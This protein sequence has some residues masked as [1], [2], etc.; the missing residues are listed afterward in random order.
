MAARWG[1]SS[2]TAWNAVLLSLALAGP[3]LAQSNPGPVKTVPES[4]VARYL[5]GRIA[6]NAGAWDVATAN[7]GAALRQDP[8]N[9]ALMRRTFLLSLGE[10]RQEEALTLARRMTQSEQGGSFV[11]HALLVADALRA[12]RLAEATERVGKLPADGM[13]PYIGPLLQ[14]W[15]A[16]AQGDSDKAVKALDP[17]SAHDGFQAIRTQQL[18]MIEDLRGNRDAAFRHFAEAAN[19]G[20]PLRL[21]LLIGNF[22]ERAGAKD[23]ARKLYTSFLSANPGNMPVEEALA[24]LDRPGP[25][26][27]LVDN[28]A[29][30]LAE[31]LFSLASALHHEGALEMALLYGRVSL[32]L[33][34][35]QPLARILVGDI[36]SARDR[37]ETALTEYRTIG[38]TASPAMQWMARLRQVEVLRE[39]KHGEEATALLEKMAAERPERTDALLRLGDMHRIA[40]HNDAA[41]AAYDKAL[42]RVK[43]PGPGDWALHY[44][45]AM[46][47]DAKGD[48]PGAEA[49][50]KQALALQPDQPSVLNY[51]GYSYIDRGIRMEEG[52]ALIEKALAARPH[53]GFITDSLGW[54][55]F[56]LGKME[57]AVDLLEKALELEPSDPSINDHLGDAYWAVGRRDEA[58]FQWTRA[59][60]QADNEGLRKSAQ[61]KLKNGLETVKAEGAAP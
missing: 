44:A 29:A 4:A 34:S 60:Q 58:R 11:A 21:T 36:L 14:A 18:A 19:Q 2:L 37:D 54:A 42:A 27:R 12:G 26:P 17:L 31:A 22:Q 6:Q 38:V 10:G 5:T 23:A 35:N 59:A 20:T 25:T 7:L 33:N 45:R 51:L 32:L 43:S 41:L 52:K 39:L 28:A 3:S 48:W 50:L 46:A 30:G 49:G 13:A 16:V 24:R 1:R 55:Q 61:A 56:K 8:D 15:I 47:L 9:P 40:K 53:D 57:A